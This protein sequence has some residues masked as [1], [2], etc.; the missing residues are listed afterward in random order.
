MATEAKTHIQI[1]TEQ[2][3]FFQD[4][5]CPGNIVFM[6]DGANLYELLKDYLCISMKQRKYQLVKTPLLYKQR[7]WEASGHWDQYKE[8]MFLLQN[9]NDDDEDKELTGLKPMN[10]PGHSLVFKKMMPSE[11]DL[12]LRLMEFGT[13]HRN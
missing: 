3:L 10:C 9:T 8:N 1:G 11:K 13:L 12:P 6:P 7:L 2:K 4:P 5:H